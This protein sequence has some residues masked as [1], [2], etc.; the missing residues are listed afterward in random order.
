MFP[1][2]LLL[3]LE[4]SSRFVGFDHRSGFGSGLDEWNRPVVDDRVVAQIRAVQLFSG[5]KDSAGSWTNRTF[6]DLT[7]QARTPLIC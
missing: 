4:L 1:N 5:R 3:F 6:T 7:L 2:L